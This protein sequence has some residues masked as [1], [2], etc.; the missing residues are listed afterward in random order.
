MLHAATCNLQWLQLAI[1]LRKKSLHDTSCRKRCYTL[2]LIDI[3]SHASLCFPVQKSI[4]VDTVKCKIHVYE[5]DIL[6]I[7]H[8]WFICLYSAIL[9]VKP[10]STEDESD[11]SWPVMRSCDATANETS[12]LVALSLI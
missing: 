1:A 11:K 4:T 6:S 5:R 2:Q 8:V 3:Y 7:P 9:I 12:T 10:R